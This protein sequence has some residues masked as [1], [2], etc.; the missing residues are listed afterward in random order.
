MRRY[1]PSGDQRH[2]Q[3]KFEHAADNIYKIVN[4][5]SGLVIDVEHGKS[6]AEIKQYIS[7]N[8][9]DDRQHWR[10]ILLEALMS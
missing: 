7:W 6:D 1:E 5:R 4:R 10:L 9:P 8:A 2:R 3:W